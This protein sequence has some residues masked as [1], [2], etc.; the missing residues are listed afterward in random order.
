MTDHLDDLPTDRGKIDKQQLDALTKY[1]GSKPNEKSAWMNS[2]KWKMVGVLLAAF[3]ILSNSITKG[4]VSSVFGI[5]E[6]IKLTLLTCVIFFAV[7]LIT[8][9]MM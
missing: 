7:A 9:M 1:F 6:G 2:S 3:F 8:V 5:E 4:I